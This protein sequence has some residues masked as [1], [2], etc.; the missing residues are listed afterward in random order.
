M[1]SAGRQKRGREGKGRERVRGRESSDSPLALFADFRPEV[2]RGAPS[3]EWAS[4]RPSI[5]RAVGE[6]GPRRAKGA[7]GGCLSLLSRFALLPSDSL[8][9]TS[10]GQ[11]PAEA[12]AEP[13][14]RAASLACARLR[15]LWRTRKPRADSLIF[16]LFAYGARTCFLGTSLSRGCQARVRGRKRLMVPSLGSRCSLGGRCRGLCFFCVGPA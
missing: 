16:S 11:S 10:Q 8:L 2:A 7:G 9:R 6:R 5:A 15:A 12:P 4:P 1:D 14:T 3:Q 13:P